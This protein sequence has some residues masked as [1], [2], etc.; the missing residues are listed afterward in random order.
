MHILYL[1]HDLSDPTTSKRVRMLKAGGASVTVAG[2]TREATPATIAKSETLSLGR[3]Y[4]GRFIQ[5]VGLV[6]RHVLF[7]RRHHNIFARADIII[8]RNLETL[9]IAV[10]GRALSGKPTPIVYEVLDI[11]R[12]LLRKDAVGSALRALEGWLAKSASLLI[13]SSPAFISQYFEAMSHVKLPHL[14]LENKVFDEQGNLSAHHEP[15]RNAPPWRIGWFGAIR[16]R[17]SLDI[18]CAVADANPDL[19]E[20]VIRGRV[21]HDQFE[22]FDA[23]VLRSKQVSFLGPYRNPDAL[24]DIYHEVHFSWAIDMFEEGQNSTWLL[25]NRVYEGGLF[26]AVPLAAEGVETGKLITRLGIGKVL[27]EPKAESLTSFLRS[28]SMESYGAMQRAVAKVDCQ[29]FAMTPADCTA[30]VTQLRELATHANAPRFA[31][32]PEAPVDSP[33]LVII[34]SLNEA[35]HIEAL[36]NYLL[37][38]SAETPMSIVIADGGS[39]DGTVE[40]VQRLAS[41][42]ANVHYLHNPKRIQ[43][44]AVNLAVEQFGA[45]HYYL[46]RL[47]A[48]AGYPKGYCRTVLEEARKIDAASVVVA[49]HT[50]AFQPGFQEAVAAAQNSKLGNG[51]SSHRLVQGEGKWVDH[52]HH[53]LMRISAYREIGGYD[54]CF[55]HNEDAEL[56]ARLRKAGYRI[57]LTPN[58]V[59]D[60]YPRSKPWPLFKQYRGYGRGRVRNLLRHRERPKLRQMIP[61][62]V[63]PAIALLMLAPWCWLMVIPFTVWASICLAYGARIAQNANKPSLALSGPAAMIMHAAWSLGFWQGLFDYARGAKR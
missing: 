14:L 41:A 8:A 42:H 53:A 47:D 2:F 15:K 49:V 3:S 20:V 38:E 27:A 58:T 55:S 7:A 22:D 48:H 33:A 4:N 10:R 30:F 13:T 34:P 52:G 50:I 40:I 32:A 31:A 16:C 59:M 23:K 18:L 62:A 54:E 11:H 19:L 9:A 63:A 43:S 46:I 61:V 60:Y 5:R 28:V 57:W 39:N 35:K 26:G 12:L 24:A 1:T 44:A 21:S 51:G 25:P 17:K 45:N 29:H 6:L 36:V 37:E 56:D